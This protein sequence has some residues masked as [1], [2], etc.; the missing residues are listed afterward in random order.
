MTDRVRRTTTVLL[1]TPVAMAAGFYLASFGYRL[2]TQGLYWMATLGLIVLY[3]LGV[4]APIVQAPSYVLGQ[5]RANETAMVVTGVF[6]AL[7]VLRI[8]LGAASREARGASRRAVLVGASVLGIAGAAAVADGMFGVTPYGDHWMPPGDYAD[9]R[10][11]VTCRLRVVEVTRRR[12][13]A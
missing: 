6:G 10:R 7:L 9:A 8:V 11:R 3:L 2:V 1:V 4:T 13:S 12:A 5:V